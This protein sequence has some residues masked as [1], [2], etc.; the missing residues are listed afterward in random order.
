VD[1]ITQKLREEIALRPYQ[2][3]A[4]MAL[5]AA[6]A[7]GRALCVL[8]TGT[9]KTCIFSHLA[10]T[11]RVPTLVLAHR[12]ELLEQARQK[13]LRYF[14]EAEIGIVGAG[15]SQWDSPII[16]GN[17]QTLRNH[18]ERLRAKDIRLVICDE[19]HHAT[20]NN[21]YAQ[22]FAATPS[23]FIVGFTATPER[24]DGKS[25]VDIFGNPVYERNIRDMVQEGWLC[26]LR[27]I[28]VRSRASLDNVQKRMGDFSE[29]QLARELD[30]ETRNQLVVEAYL[31]HAS[32][33]RA[34]CFAIN[35][36]HAHHIASR[37]NEQ[38]IAAIALDGK[39]PT[40]EREY[41]LEQFGKG[42]LQIL[43]NCELF[44]E[45]FDAPFV[46]CIIMARP[47]LSHS[48][49]LQMIG[50][51]TRIY[52]G[53][54]ECLILDI[55]DNCSKHKLA[56]QS[57][58]RVMGLPSEAGNISLL[59]YDEQVRQERVRAQLAEIE[60]IRKDEAQKKRA[61][62]ERREITFAEIDLFGDRVSWALLPDETIVAKV[63]YATI[64]IM[65]IDEYGAYS[66]L[67]S[68]KFKTSCLA[69]GVRLADAKDMAEQYAREVRDRIA[70]KSQ[71]KPT[72]KQIEAMQ[73]MH[74]PI[75]VGCTFGQAH[76]LISARIAQFER[77]GNSKSKSKSRSA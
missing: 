28:V 53:K 6:R 24:L 13:L 2:E 60:R 46:E 9:G 35:V 64:T 71:N 25:I 41:A 23:A 17:I 68:D 26:D 59:E 50:R 32:G 14:N 70:A 61:V 15:Y 58:K 21:T 1:S 18:L 51:G 47:T 63:A 3:E 31:R 62:Q 22:V 27:G 77:S 4:L 11:L 39:T 7:G 75:P 12:K 74:I 69:Y 43:V 42:K 37:F 48:L 52:D 20:Y 16:V 38:E 10:H 57:F 40:E 5:L 73:K 30:E 36:A 56:P 45:G 19:S 65:P 44:T 8:P 34:I 76:D 29:E 55:A 54:Q 49:F 33:K 66:V 72:A 67:A